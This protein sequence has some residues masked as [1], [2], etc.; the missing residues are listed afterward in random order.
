MEHHDGEHTTTPGANGHDD[1]VLALPETVL[2]SLG[3]QIAEAGGEYQEPPE[4]AGSIGRTMF[5]TPSSDDGTVTVLL[6][7]EH[8]GALP[9]QSLVRIESV[10]DKRS[11]LGAVVKGPFAE[12]D[13]LRADAPIIVTSTVRGAFLLP[14]YHGRVQV[15]ILGEELDDGT[16]VPPR[17]RPLPNSPVFALPSGEAAR[18]LRTGGNVCLGVAESYE[19]IEIRVPAEV[20]AVFPRHLGV[21]GTTGGGKSTTVSGLIGQLQEAGVAV[22]ILDTEGEY[23][24][25]GDATEDPTMQRALARRG[26]EPKG[27]ENTHVYHLVGKGTRNPQHPSRT[28]FRVDFSALSPHAVKE[29]LDFTPAQETRFFQAYRHLLQE[30]A[31]ARTQAA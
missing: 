4:Y 10:P 31:V 8:I 6:P 27:V 21:L 11:Y 18:V 14:K 13:G 3:R 20:K 28:A 26:R 16:V 5:D 17:R 12:P 15:A 25:I 22:V 23:T 2:A 24:A 30:C 9:S 19:D 7:K 29:I 1:G